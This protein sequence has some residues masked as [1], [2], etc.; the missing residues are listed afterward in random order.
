MKNFLGWG[1]A[2]YVTAPAAVKSG[3]PLL[4]GALFGFCGADA[5]IN[6]K[7]ALHVKGEFSASPKL[8]G[9]AWTEGL[10]IFWDNADKR[11]TTTSTSGN[12]RIGVAIEAAA[13][14]DTIGKIRLNGRP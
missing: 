12:T 9:T 4:V 7:V 3:D 14:A 2:V 6:T 8:A 11:F 5:A 13:S 10:A 1:R